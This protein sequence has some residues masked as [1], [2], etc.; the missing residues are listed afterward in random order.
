MGDNVMERYEGQE[1]KLDLACGDNKKEGFV[2]VDIA[3]TASTDIVH[4][5]LEYPWP[6]A[7]NSVDALHCSHYIEHIPM[8]EINGK[9]ALFAFF[10]E[11]YRILKPGAALEIW[12]PCARSNRAFQDPTH[13][14]FIVGETFLYAN[15]EWRDANKLGHYNVQCDFNLNV[16][17]MVAGELT[18]LHPEAAG[19][20]INESWNVVFDWKAILIKK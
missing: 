20:R 15:K 18:L 3:K 13:R 14:R 1:L 17:P 5:L 7:D 10:D 12:C 9:D 4:N 2:G 16:D 19:R 6:F 11:C 8:I